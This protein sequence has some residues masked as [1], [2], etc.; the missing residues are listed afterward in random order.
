[1]AARG[2]V[3]GDGDGYACSAPADGAS[4]R[5]GS[6]SSAST[7]S[8][9]QLVLERLLASHDKRHDNG[10]YFLDSWAGPRLVASKHAK[11]T[12]K[13]W[14]VDGQPGAGAG[15]GATVAGVVRV[16]AYTQA[17]P[18]LRDYLIRSHTMLS[19]SSSLVAV[20]TRFGRTV[21][22]WN[23]ATGKC[24]HAITD[25]DRWTA[26]RSP[27][28]GRESNALAVYRAATRPITF[29]GVGGGGG[30]ERRGLAHGAVI[31]LGRA[32]LP[33]VPQYPELAL[34]STGPLLVA[35]AGPRPPKPGGP[36]PAKQTL[37]AA[38]ET[39]GDGA[40]PPRLH[41]VVR[42]WQH[43]EI[44]T[45][46]P[47]Q[48]AVHGSVAVSVWIPASFQAVPSPA[49]AGFHLAHVAVRSRHVLVWDLAEACTW[50]FAIPSCVACISPDCRH[51]DYCH[52]SGADVDAR[53]C[54]TIVDVRDGREVWSW[55]DKDAPAIHSGPRS[56]FEQ[57]EDL[58]GV[59]ELAFSADGACLMVGDRSGASACTTSGRG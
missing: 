47:C 57:F 27:G 50:T 13:I 58:G 4:G 25:A 22:I 29:Y 26:G 59:T 51:V 49:G 1:M 52:A 8:T 55:P 46:V 43:A 37:L 30:P 6:G 28:Q 16:P 17:Q 7:T 20:T 39:S 12:I 54:L 48:L 35:A 21:K 2:V 32:K 3:D 19:A 5:H 9:M 11:D 41:R 23:W 45:A 40:G 44:A 34:S 24:L 56:G 53:G 18:R 15:A 33:F 36:P 42:P 31:D 14:R 38:W 10:V